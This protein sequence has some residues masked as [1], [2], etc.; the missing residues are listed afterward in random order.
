MRDAGYEKL[1]VAG[2][3]R[4]VAVLIAVGIDREGKRRILGVSVELKDAEIHRRVFLD[5]F[6]HRVISGVEYIVSDDH[7]GLKAARR[8]VF[9]GSKWQR[10]QYNLIQDSM[11]QAPKEEIR[12]GLVTELR[13]VYY[14]ETLKIAGMP[15]DNAVT[16]F[17][18]ETPTLVKWL[19]KVRQ[20][21]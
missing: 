19:K 10:C 16:K 15:L 18:S 4:D 9:T 6:V 2:I 12:K 7:P 13:I 17:S 11:K 21:F 14:V 3:V 8:A 20:I 1:R 5:H